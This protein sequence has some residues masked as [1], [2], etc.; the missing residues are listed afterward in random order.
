M[1]ISQRLAELQSAI[2]HYATAPAVTVVAVSKYAT[3]SQVMEAYE[4]GV[5][6]F[7]ENKVQ[8]AL[9]KMA[10]LP[11]AM[12]QTIRWHLIGNLQSNKVKKTVGRFAL[13][14]SI[15][16]LRLAEAISRHNQQAGRRQPVL[17]QVN[18]SDD[19]TRH[20]FLPDEIRS[21]LPT[22]LSL[23]AMEVRG[24]MGMA[25]PEASLSQDSERLK[26]VFCGLRALRDD[27]ARDLAIDLPELSMGMT[28]DFPHALA[29][30]ATIIRIGNYLFKN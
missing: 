8:D 22:L 5:R 10:Q 2:R 30:G 14:H 26:A 20:G 3:V 9:E 15:D 24:L 1:S 23:D 27:L 4:A 16:S 21:V 13:I 25:P 7:G 28:H 12:Q 18:L 11:P 6:D 29:C 19:T 17:L